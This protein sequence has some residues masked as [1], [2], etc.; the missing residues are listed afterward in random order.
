MYNVRVIMACRRFRRPSRVFHEP[1]R[2]LVELKK[3]L[4]VLAA[5]ALFAGCSLAPHYQKPAVE[6]P[7]AFKENAGDT[8]IWKVARPDDA[9]IRGKWWE[10]FGDTNLNA[11]EDQVTVSN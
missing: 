5:T 3:T 11:L 2:F 1:V 9:A 6:T 7:A 10:M 4:I 8:N